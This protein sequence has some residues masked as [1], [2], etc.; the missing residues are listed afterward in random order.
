MA[1]SLDPGPCKFDVI[2]ASEWSDMLECAKLNA[3]DRWPRDD[4]ERSSARALD[5]G[6]AWGHRRISRRGSFRFGG[7]TWQANE[8][9][10]LAG[11]VVGVHAGDYIGTWVELYKSYPHGRMFATL[12]LT[13]EETK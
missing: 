4:C 13:V 3:G 6:V 1:R 8:L 12:S 5:G 9:I 2:N 10:P 11:L 7:M